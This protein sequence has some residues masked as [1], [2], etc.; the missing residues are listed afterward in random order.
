MAAEV[1]SNAST[2]GGLRLSI[3]AA[4]RGARR[5]AILE[6][7]QVADSPIL[8]LRGSIVEIDAASVVTRRTPQTS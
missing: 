1:A 2:R 4:R 5:A 7:W 6:I 3:V 8:P